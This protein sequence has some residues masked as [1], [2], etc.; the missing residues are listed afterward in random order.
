[1]TDNITYLSLDA[2]TFPVPSFVEF[3]FYAGGSILTESTPKA[4]FSL[5]PSG[6]MRFRWTEVNK[7][8]SNFFKQIL[9]AHHTI[10]PIELIHSKTV[11][12]IEKDTPWINIRGDGL[13]TQ[14]HSVVPVITA[15]DC[16]PIYLYNPKIQCF[17]VLH[18]GWKGTGIAAEA[19]KLAKKNFGARSEDFHII[20][21]PHIQSCCYTV[22]KERANYF[23]NTFTPHCITHSH[24]EYH[25]SLAQANISMLQEE[26]VLPQNIA[27]YS[28]C[29]SC[30]RL[31]GKP[32]LGSFRRETAGISSTSAEELSFHFTPMAAFMYMN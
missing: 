13:L 10:F 16:M 19:L 17:G 15:A 26:G 9:S 5:L 2:L 32:Y 31:F 23:S 21:G 28:D 24:N 20:L 6:S 27:C 1:M 29:T 18:S 25:L 4:C 30:G 11:Y 3:P 22:D 12:I 8:R 7:N 14:D